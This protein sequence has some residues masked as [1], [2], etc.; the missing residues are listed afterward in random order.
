MQFPLPS[1]G[2]KRS[3]NFRRSHRKGRPKRGLGF[4]AG[5]AKMAKNAVGTFVGTLLQNGEYFWVVPTLPLA[6]SI[7]VTI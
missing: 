1:G 6:D 5:K 3:T 2:Q 7:A 4:L